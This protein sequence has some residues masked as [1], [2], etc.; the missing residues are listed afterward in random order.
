MLKAK[1]KSKF[2]VY[3]LHK[4]CG[5]IPMTIVALRDFPTTQWTRTFWLL[6]RICSSRANDFSNASVISLIKAIHKMKIMQQSNSHTSP[7]YSTQQI[8]INNRSSG[9]LLTL[10]SA[11]SESQ[12]AKTAKLLY[13]IKNVKKWNRVV[14]YGVMWRGGPLLRHIEY[15]GHFIRQEV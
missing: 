2:S 1:C 12:P 8:E 14:S 10:I 5:Q 7:G 6:S 3:S 9:E 13:L 11:S 4:C 15:V